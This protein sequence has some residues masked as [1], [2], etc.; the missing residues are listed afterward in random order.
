MQS[1]KDKDKDKDYIA[2][3]IKLER[4]KAKLTQLELAEKAGISAKQLSRIE[5]GE[6][7]PSLT[8]YLKIIDVLKINVNDFGIIVN[9]K[10]NSLLKKMLTIIYSSDENQ[11]QLYLDII[12]AIIKN[13][14]PKNLSKF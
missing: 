5:T 11:L 3:K 10:E 1:N 2:K 12:N 7:M 4:K 14:K 6:F 8:T 13:S 9:N